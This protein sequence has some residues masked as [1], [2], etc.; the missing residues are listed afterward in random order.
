MDNISPAPPAPPAPPARPAPA[1]KSFKLFGGVDIAAATFDASCYQ[2]GVSRNDRPEKALHYRQS[3]EDY[4][5]FSQSL[6]SK[7]ADPASIVIVLEATSTYWINLALYLYENGFGVRV[8]NPRQAHHHA[9]SDLKTTKTDAID[10]QTLADLAA[11]RTHKL[12]A[13]SPPPAIH[14]QLEQRI[15]YRSTLL[16]LRKVLKNQLHALSASQLMVEA[17]GEMYRRQIADFT[18]K[19]EALEKEIEK[20]LKTDVAWL[21]SVT[22]LQTISGVGPITAYWLV[23]ATLNFTSCTKA[24]SLAKYVG[25]APEV[26]Q[27][28]TSIKGRGGIG[29]S[30]HRQLRTALYMAAQ[31]AVRFNPV[32]KAF[33]ERLIAAGKPRKVAV[34]AVARKL[35]HIAFALKRSG[36]PFDC[37]IGR[38]KEAKVEIAS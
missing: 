22:L 10:A 27:S 28:G 37:E 11:T 23:V 36:E 38:Q 25:L 1:K 5:K 33:F 17:V 16:E 35:I 12:K 32:L 8:I 2:P 14:H 24:D 4:T 21:E 7:E 26:K 3:Q 20:V 15:Q 31:S 29:Y 19:I 13:W 34:C 30:G 9:L 6:L 18:A